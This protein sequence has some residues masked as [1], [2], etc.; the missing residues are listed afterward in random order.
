MSITLR[1]PPDTCANAKLISIR[2]KSTHLHWNG[3]SPRERRV[4]EIRFAYAHRFGGPHYMHGRRQRRMEDPN[5]GSEFW[6]FAKRKWIFHFE[7]FAGRKIPG[8][9]AATANA[10]CIAIWTGHQFSR[11]IIIYRMPPPTSI[12]VLLVNIYANQKSSLSF[13]LRPLP[14]IQFRARKW[15]HCM[16]KSFEWKRDEVNLQ[17]VVNHWFVHFGLVT[18]AHWK[19]RAMQNVRMRVFQL[20]GALIGWTTSKKTAHAAHDKYVFRYTVAFALEVSYFH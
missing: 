18:E 3:Y 10:K 19:K 20:G 2:T 16:R 6:N 17:I 9:I 8:V 13:I 1:A 15:N 14:P 12:P 7:Y 5:N 4:D 11:R